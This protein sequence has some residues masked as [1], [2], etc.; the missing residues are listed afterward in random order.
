MLW[1][2]VDVV[3]AVL[4]LVV[5]ALVALA[6]WRR[7]T[8]LGRAVGAAGDQL[9]ALAARL[10]GLADSGRPSPATPVAARR[11]R[12]ARPRPLGV[13]SAPSS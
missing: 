5:L 9:S 10:D 7:V 12:R 6:V 4:A 11:A 1:V 13:R 2:L 3:L 8:A